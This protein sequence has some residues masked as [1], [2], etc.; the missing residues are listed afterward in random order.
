MTIRIYNINTYNGIAT[1]KTLLSRVIELL[2]NDPLQIKDFLRRYGIRHRFIVPYI[3]LQNKIAEHET[4]TLTDIASGLQSSEEIHSA[5]YLKN[6]CASKS[7]TAKMPF[8][9]WTE[10]LP[11]LQHLSV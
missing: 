4:R 7:N 5:N 9:E 10:K 2:N 11:S 1:H 6:G 8:Q 3:S